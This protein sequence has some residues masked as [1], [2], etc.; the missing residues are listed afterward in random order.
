MTDQCLWRNWYCYISVTN[1]LQQIIFKDFIYL[2]ILNA[3]IY[4]KRLWNQVI[5]FW[6]TLNKFGKIVNNWHFKLSSQT[7]HVNY[8][9]LPLTLWKAWLGKT[10]V[11][12]TT[13]FFVYLYTWCSLDAVI[14]RLPHNW[15]KGCL[16]VGRREYCTVL[17]DCMPA[18]PN[19]CWKEVK[20]F[21]HS[22][23]THSYRHS[24]KIKKSLFYLEFMYLIK[25]ISHN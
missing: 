1:M 22:G 20:V 9:L 5:L 16:N 3:T 2:V 6:Q 17:T 12:R 19:N 10:V 18:D 23:C 11:Y 14:G 7:H 13:N 8:Y 24:Y 25:H 21:P 4:V 15:T